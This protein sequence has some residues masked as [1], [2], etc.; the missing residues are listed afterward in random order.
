[1]ILLTIKD[2]NKYLLELN[3]DDKIGQLYGKIDYDLHNILL[4]DGPIVIYRNNDTKE[5]KVLIGEYGDYHSDLFPQMI[6]FDKSYFGR[7]YIGIS[8]AHL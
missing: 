7:G 2:R 3:N 5:D 1:M 8:H 6:N 4:R